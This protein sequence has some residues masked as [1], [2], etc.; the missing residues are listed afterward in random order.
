MN[1]KYIKNDIDKIIDLYNIIDSVIIEKV[2]YREIFDSSIEYVYGDSLAEYTEHSIHSI[3]VNNIRHNYSNYD[4]ITRLM[5]RINRSPNDY[6]Q[7]KNCVLEKISNIY[8]FLKDECERQKR[9]F[10]MVDIVSR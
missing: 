2:D 5:H 10:N 8:P 6:D 1:R 7:Y 9:K 4:D 3:M